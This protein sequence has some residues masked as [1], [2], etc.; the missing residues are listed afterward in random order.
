LSD[1]SFQEKF[2]KVINTEP[3]RYL[4]RKAAALPMLDY[5]KSRLELIIGY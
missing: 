3:K 4:K 5:K 1:L 2:K